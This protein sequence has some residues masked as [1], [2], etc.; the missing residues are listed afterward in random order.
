MR[1]GVGSTEDNAAKNS[2]FTIAADAMSS[3]NPIQQSFELAAERCDDLTPLVYRRLFRQHP[4]AEA[5]FRREERSR[6]GIDAGAD[7]RCDTGFCRR[8]DG[9]LSHD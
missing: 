1:V 7:H 6:E 5:M 4:E 3:T 8:S 9:Q 2:A